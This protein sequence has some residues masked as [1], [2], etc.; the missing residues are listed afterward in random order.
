MS[1]NPVGWFEIYVQDM[2]RARRFYESVLGVT[3]SEL[4][5]P[6][7]AGFPGMEMWAFPGAMEGYGASG[8]LVQM[9]DMA[10]GGGGTIV[11]FSTEDCGGV[12]ARAVE[13]GGS[14]VSPKASIGEHGYC[15]L[16]KDPDGNV[17]GLH[18]MQ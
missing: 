2:P 14:L 9:P 17:I 7:P 5:N 4:A 6:D 8:A 13:S 15:A 11:Y 3:L 16:V 18:S 1:G 10:S 12:A